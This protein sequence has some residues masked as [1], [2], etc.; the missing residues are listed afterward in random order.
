[1]SVTQ[2]ASAIEVTPT[3]IRQRLTRLMAKNLIEREAVRNG[4]GRPKHRYQLTQKGLRL[5]GSNFT[6]LALALWREIGQ[7]EDMETRRVLIQRVIRALASG[8]AREI[9]GQTTAERMRSISRLLGQ[10][11]IPFSV[12]DGGI[13]DLPPVLTAHACPYPELAEEDRGICILER[14]AVLGIARSGCQTVGVPAGRQPLLSIS[15]HRLSGYTGKFAAARA[16]HL[17]PPWG[18]HRVASR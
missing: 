8:Y 11:R 6:D 3:A 7:I 9:Q 5:T 12:D 4:R 14:A 10:R 13:S 1:M 17:G 15:A 2:M 16:L 18:S